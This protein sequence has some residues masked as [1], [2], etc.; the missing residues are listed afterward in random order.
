MRLMPRVAIAFDTDEPGS[1]GTPAR[2]PRRHTTEPRGGRVIQ[3]ERHVHRF[4]AAG[5]DHERQSEPD[6]FDV[7]RAVLARGMA[8]E[9]PLPRGSYGPACYWDAPAR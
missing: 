4:G 9:R 2:T 6:A 5:P 1:R 7:Q 3:R 8:D